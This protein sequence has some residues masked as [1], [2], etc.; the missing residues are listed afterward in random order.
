MGGKGVG[1]RDFGEGGNEVRSR[2]EFGGVG[3]KRT[4]RRAGGT[5]SGEVDGKKRGEKDKNGRDGKF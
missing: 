2:G 1:G 4:G 3:E 5:A